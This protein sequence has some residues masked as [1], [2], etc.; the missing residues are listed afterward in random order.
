MLPGGLIVLMLVGE[1]GLVGWL[2]VRGV[3][4]REVALRGR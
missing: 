3:D 2:L 1:L 4:A